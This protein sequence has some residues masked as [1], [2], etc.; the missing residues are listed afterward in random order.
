MGFGFRLLGLEFSVWGP[1]FKVQDA[2]LK[3][4]RIVGLTVTR[5]GQPSYT[6]NTPCTPYP[7]PYTVHYTLY[8][9]NTTLYTMFRVQGYPSSGCRG[10]VHGVGSRARVKGSWRRAQ[11]Y[12]SSLA[13]AGLTVEFGSG[14]SLL[15]HIPLYSP[16]YGG[17]WREGRVEPLS[18]SLSLARALSLFSLTPLYTV[19]P[20]VHSVCTVPSIVHTLCSPL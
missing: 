8:T 7:E 9:I 3:G 12:P 1:G 15:D 10:R 11:G 6:C 5:Q 20:I 2:E 13:A 14:G 19:L 17:V 18:L 16:L 4:T